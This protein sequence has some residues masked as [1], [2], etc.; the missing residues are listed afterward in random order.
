MSLKCIFSTRSFASK[1]T[2][3]ELV[4]TVNNMR[5]NAVGGPVEAQIQAKAGDLTLGSLI[6]YLRYPV[7]IQDETGR[8]VWWGYVHS[9]EVTKGKI[10]YGI[11]LDRL[12][13]KVS[14]KYSHIHPG[15]EEVG[16]SRTTTAVTDVESSAEFGTKE[17]LGSLDSASDEVANGYR[18]TLLARTK[19]PTM[20]PA[21]GSGGEGALLVCRG[22][23][24]TL[25]WLFYA[26]SNTTDQVTTDQVIAIEAA[27]GQFITGVDIVQ[28]SGISSSEYRDG[29]H[30]AKAEMEELLKSGTSSYRR[31]L[32]A[33]GV[34]RRLAISEEPV[35]PSRATY[36]IGPDGT[37]QDARG[38]AIESYF[39]PVGV[40]AQLKDVI[41][42]T[43]DT[44]R[45]TD[46]SWI[47]IDEISW[48]NG[49][50]TIIPRDSPG[51][52]DIGGIQ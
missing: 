39:A 14:V 29:T 38:L 44:S 27:A 26:N 17:Q 4:F 24:D 1:I 28:A 36:F 25:D 19:Y 15:I 7:V 11:T 8:D 42:P 5:W 12:A 45:I 47:F 43:V 32:A 10:S 21:F 22:W 40:W 49:E 13:N 48:D 2:D 18:D 3:P 46:P 31:L 23:Y 50:L 51:Y 16:E 52:M 33:V 35:R 30:T 41:P 34:D 6:D 20:L 9:V 37:F